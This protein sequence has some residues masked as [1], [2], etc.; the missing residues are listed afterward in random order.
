MASAFDFI[1]G[2]FSEWNTIRISG[3]WT[4]QLAIVSSVA[5]GFA[6]KPGMVSPNRCA[7]G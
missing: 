2:I 5:A 3:V 6:Q 7:C 1:P 4:L